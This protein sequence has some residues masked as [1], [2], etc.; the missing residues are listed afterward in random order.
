MGS[1]ADPDRTRR[2]HGTDPQPHPRMATATPRP[3]HRPKEGTSG[4]RARR[5]ADRVLDDYPPDHW[6]DAFRDIV[7]IEPHRSDPWAKCGRAYHK[8]ARSL[9]VRRPHRGQPRRD[10]LP[11]PGRGTDDLTLHP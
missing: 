5:L 6:T 9:A 10:G 7:R 11:G 3:A 1:H 2:S 4:R 8:T